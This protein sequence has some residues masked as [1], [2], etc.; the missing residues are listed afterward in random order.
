MATS[1]GSA[2][3][4]ETAK[5]EEVPTPEGGEM[6]VVAKNPYRGTIDD[7]DPGWWQRL[8]YEQRI[9]LYIPA[10]PELG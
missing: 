9:G 4:K 10:V 7:E 3:G 2:N 8:R 6:V 1:N 5:E